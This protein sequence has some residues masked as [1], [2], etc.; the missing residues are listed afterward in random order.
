MMISR[1]HAPIGPSALRWH[2][3]N[4][5]LFTVSGQ[6][7][8]TLLELVVVVIVV[9]VLFLAALNKVWSLQTT[10]ERTTMDYNI[11]A[12][13]SALALQF[14]AMIVRKDEEGI[15]QLAGSNPMTLLNQRPGNYLGEFTG[16]DPA[17]LE[18]GHWYFDRQQKV[19]T[20]LVKN[21][22]FF[23][24]VLSGPPRVRWSVRLDV[25]TPDSSISSGLA[26]DQ[27]EGLSLVPME[28]YVWR[29]EE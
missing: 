17:S 18:S 12:L 11:G 4:S 3:R 10:V 16:V 26:L 24:S 1:S 19:L 7:G 5:R 21:R 28:G 2:P 22:Q 29:E 9:S 13:R 15:R 27:L 25:A 23:Q 14:V 8:F 20:Y 6:G